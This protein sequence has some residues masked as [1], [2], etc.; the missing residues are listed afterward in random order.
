MK[1]DESKIAR[2]LE[3][4]KRNGPLT[5]TD[6]MCMSGFS[7]STCRH[8]LHMLLLEKSIHAA[9]ER[10]HGGG[11]IFWYAAGWKDTPTAQKA[12]QIA[13]ESPDVSR[14]HAAPPTISRT[15]MLSM[16][17]HTAGRKPPKAARA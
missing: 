5:T 2:I 1:P 3:L 13:Q 14:V 17:W 6:V 4:I 11:Y 9:S 8:Y 12:F 15:D 16:I 7:Q 10:R